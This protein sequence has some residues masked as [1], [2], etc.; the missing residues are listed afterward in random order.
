MKSF[1]E[2]LRSIKFPDYSNFT[3]VN[4]AYQDL[5]TKSLSVIDF[6]APIRTLI[7]NF[8]VVNAIRYRGKHYKKFKRRDK[9]IVKDNFKCE[10]LSYFLY[11]FPNI[12]DSQRQKLPRPKNKFRINTTDEYYNQIWNEYEDSALHNIDVTTVDKILKNL[13]AAKS[14]GIDQISAIFLKDGAPVIPAHLVKITN[15]SIKHGTFPP[16]M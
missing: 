10:I 15:L 5:V 1:L 11:V 13:D 7:A 6:I 3:C 16:K 14:S 9:E 4:D 12:I 8:G 2:Q